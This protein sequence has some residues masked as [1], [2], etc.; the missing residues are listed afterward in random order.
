MTTHGKVQFERPA[1]PSQL[2]YFLRV[3]ASGGKGAPVLVAVHGISRNA[4]E[5][6]LRFAATPDWDD[7]VIV[8]PLFER[9]V[10]GRYQQLEPARSGLRSDLALLALLDHLTDAGMAGEQV[11]LFGFSG[12]AQF[13]HRF[14]LHH[15]HRLRSLSLAAAGWYTVPD[16][17]HPFPMGLGRGPDD[18]PASRLDAMLALPIQV[19]VGEMDTR[20]DATLRSS[21]WLD[22]T[23]GRNRLERAGAWVGALR[24]AARDRGIEPRLMLDVLSACGHDFGQCVLDADMLGRVARNLLRLSPTSQASGNEPWSLAD[25]PRPMAVRRKALVAG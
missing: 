15:P 8:A 7:H 12:G 4:A 16:E 20:R 2:G 24:A 17:T 25:R 13:A 23:Q 3:P 6:A 18:L 21:P 10:F 5:H 22:Q 9:R 14:G 1:D 19:M 11:D